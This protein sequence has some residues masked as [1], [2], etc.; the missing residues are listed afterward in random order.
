MPGTDLAFAAT[1]L[2]TCYAMSSTELAYGGSSLPTCYA[3]RGT[4]LAY[5]GD[6]GTELA[7]GSDVR[8]CASVWGVRGTDI[9]NGADVEYCR[10]IQST[11]PSTDKGYGCSGA[12]AAER[13]AEYGTH[14]A[15]HR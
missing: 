6:V 7:Y 12:E 1:F 8:Y 14:A 13:G 4:E 5:G 10:R 3:M 9:A 15:Y 11:F 2:Q